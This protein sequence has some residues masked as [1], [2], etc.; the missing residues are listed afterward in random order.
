MVGGELGVVLH[1]GGIVCPQLGPQGG[2]HFF[3]R[4]DGILRAADEQKIE[5]LQI[6]KSLLQGQ[7]AVTGHGVALN[8]AGC[9]LP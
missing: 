6:I 3:R 4:G 7:V 8:R 9:L 5:L 1:C 2:D